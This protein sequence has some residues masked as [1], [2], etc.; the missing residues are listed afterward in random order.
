MKQLDDDLNDARDGRPRI[1]P[2]DPLLERLATVKEQEARRAP[3]EV[4]RGEGKDHVLLPKI[5]MLERA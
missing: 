5:D 2:R 1:A 3:A 4:A